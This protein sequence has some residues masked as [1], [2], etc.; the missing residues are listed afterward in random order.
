MTYT[1][2][3]RHLQRSIEQTIL[4]LLCTYLCI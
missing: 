2:A 3:L 1:I 4:L